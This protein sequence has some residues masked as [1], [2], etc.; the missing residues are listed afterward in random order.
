LAE[1]GVAPAAWDSHSPPRDASG[2]RPPY[3]G[4]RLQWLDGTG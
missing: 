4:G 2:H 1:P 3:Y